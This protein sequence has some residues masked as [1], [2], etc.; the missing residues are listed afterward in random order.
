MQ[1]DQSSYL[2]NQQIPIATPVLQSSQQQASASLPIASQVQI[3]L[4]QQQSTQSPYSSIYGITANTPPA[5]SGQA[6]SSSNSSQYLQLQQPYSSAY[7]SNNNSMHSVYGEMSTAGSSPYCSSTQQ[8]PNTTSLNSL[9]M[10]GMTSQNSAISDSHN[11]KSNIP[12]NYSSSDKV[13]ISNASISKPPPASRES[14]SKTPLPDIPMVFHELQSL[15]ESQLFRLLSD[16]IA[17]KVIFS[18][19]NYSQFL[20]I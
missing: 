7:G 14:S 3:P 10:Q 5:Y 17:L 18:F 2:A 12:S 9:A 15:S 16:D 19:S 11:L 8:T 13:S 6:I 1:V 20:T 4:Q